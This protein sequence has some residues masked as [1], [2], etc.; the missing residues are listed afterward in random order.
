MANRGPNSAAR[1]EVLFLLRG[2]SPPRRLPLAV[3][4]PQP[5]SPRACTVLST[6]FRSA[7]R[8]ACLLP[9]NHV[10]GHRFTAFRRAAAYPSETGPFARNGLSLARNG[11]RFRGL[12]SGVNGPGLLLRCLD[13]RLPCPFGLSAPL[14]ELVCPN[15]RRFPA[16][17]P[18]H[19]HR[20]T[21]LAVLP[22]PTPLR[23]FLLPRD[24]SVQWASL[25][26]GPPSESARFPLAPRSLLYY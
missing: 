11:S 12:H 5:C 19:F 9:G 18:L 15:P 14:P 3:P 4:S 23:E 21:H 20:Q 10:G 26:S 2:P 17:D 16:S 1:L 8:L 7:V 13:H 25:P 24:Q 6:A 22:I